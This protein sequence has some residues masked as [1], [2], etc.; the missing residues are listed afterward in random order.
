MAQKSK[1]LFNVRFDVT[2]SFLRKG[3]SHHDIVLNDKRE[4]KK[5]GFR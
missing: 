3:K 5:Y 2:L 4:N 1:F